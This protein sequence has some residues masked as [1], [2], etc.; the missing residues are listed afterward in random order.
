MPMPKVAAQFA[1]RVPNEGAREVVYRCVD[2]PAYPLD[3][4]PRLS[5]IAPGR[6]ACSPAF[7]EGRSC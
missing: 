5:N 3:G 1:N 4:D 7:I 6:W 2:R